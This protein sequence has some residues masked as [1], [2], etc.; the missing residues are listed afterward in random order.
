[1]C[2]IAKTIETREAVNY[3]KPNAIDA[4]I[5][6]AGVEPVT[7][8]RLISPPAKESMISKTLQPGQ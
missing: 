7:A 2:Q 5:F 6:I 8:N 1:M 4:K 3:L